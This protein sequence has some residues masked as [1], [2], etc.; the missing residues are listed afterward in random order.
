MHIV[1]MAGGRGTR[2]WPRSR[3]RTPKQLLN[4]VGD[5][6]MLRQTFDRVRPLADPSRVW[7]VTNEEYREAVAHQLPDLPPDH[8]IAEPLVRSTAPCIGLAALHV[9]RR[10]GDEVMAVLSADHW[11]GDEAA[12]LRCLMTGAE[13][14]RHERTI[15]TIGIQPTS[16]ETGYGYIQVGTLLGEMDGQRVHRVVRFTEKPDRETAEQFLNGGQHLWNSGIFVWTAST[17]LWHI[18]RLAPELHQ[19]LMEIER[20]LGTADEPGRVRRVYETLPTVSIDYAVMERADQV[21]V[22]LGG[23]GWSDVGSWSA[24][25][26]FWERDEHGNAVR[27]QVI[28]VDASGMIVESGG[29]LVAL[30]GVD[31]LIVIETDDVLLVC[32]KDRDQDIKRMIS[33]LERRGL[34]EYL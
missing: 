16:P 28:G 21:A 9:H 1:I 15:V 18:E 8:I 5:G 19:G 20:A 11:I 7:V 32:R 25:Q 6:T 33:E 31:D 4:I 34:T 2:F 10:A 26:P 29:K 23:F 3:S 14:A 27:G 22:V 13:V 24:V 17:I 12:F 30:I